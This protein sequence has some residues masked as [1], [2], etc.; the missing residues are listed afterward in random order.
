MYNIH[1]I[2][3]ILPHSE[4]VPVSHQDLVELCHLANNNPVISEFFVLLEGRINDERAFL[5]TVADVKR[6][7]G[8]I[9]IPC[10]R[11]MLFGLL[12]IDFI[13]AVF[14]AR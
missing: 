12:Y 13:P 2:H 7:W 1:D 8:Y 3:A 11:R 10:V 14:D 5:G 9:F 4:E 6:M